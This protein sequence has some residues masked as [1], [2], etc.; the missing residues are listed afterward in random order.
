MTQDFITFNE[1]INRKWP[2]D[3]LLHHPNPIIRFQETNRIRS[4][5][6]KAGDVRG[7]NVL[8]LGC[9]Y[10]HVLG[11]LHK[12]GARRCVGLD[13]DRNYVARANKEK[14]HLDIRLHDITQPFEHGK[15][16]DII[17]ASE[18][19][20]H[21][22][23]PIPVLQNMKAV[24]HKRSMGIIQVPNERLVIKVKSAISGLHI[25]KVISGISE[26][27]QPAHLRI[28]TKKSLRKQ[29]RTA[30]FHNIR[31]T[32]DWPFFTNYI[33]RFTI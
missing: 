28:Y 33:A 6:S 23:N 15:F 17:M 10:G 14:P 13:L 19:L 32:Y 2:M 12:M 11:L 3:L 8:D 25:G 29:L 4:F 22:T 1:D 20:E 21:V 7:R 18:V 30:G 5:V 24:M 26:G 27:R 9:G 31:I 16:Y